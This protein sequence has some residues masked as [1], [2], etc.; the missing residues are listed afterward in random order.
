MRQKAA[1]RDRLAERLL[2]V[3]P[4]AGLINRVEDG[5]RDTGHNLTSFLFD[6]TLPQEYPNSGA[7]RMDS[8]QASAIEVIG[9]FAVSALCIYLGYKLFVAGATG[10]FKFSANYRGTGVGLESVAPGLLFIFLGAVI[11]LWALYSFRLW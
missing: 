6:P 2:A 1:F 3:G 10:A 4:S 11:A 5:K 7:L 9:A 8:N